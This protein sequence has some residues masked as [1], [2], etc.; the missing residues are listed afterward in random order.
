MQRS[1]SKQ[2]EV[3]AHYRALA[4]KY[5][6]R[7]NR[8]CER[9]YRALAHR[10]LAGRDRVL[11][12]GGGSSDLL[13]SLDRPLAVACDL[14]EEMLRSRPT[15]GRT[16]RVAA[17]CERLPFDDAGF[18]AILLVNVLEHVDDLDRVL[19]ES[20]RVLRAGGL[21]LAVTPNGDWETW[22][23]LAE[24]WSL[25]IPEGPHEF[26]TSRRLAEAV[27]RRLEIVEHRTMLTLP[28][29]PPALSRWIDRL[30]ACSARGW[31]FFQYV[32]A[33]KRDCRA[34]AGGP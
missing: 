23:D 7:A 3:K 27:G 4:P 1:T 32:A 13:D 17:V 11:E 33:R 21:W 9:T 12:L 6:D 31:G 2:A 34:A 30:S 16:H 18:D 14:S 15:G 8:T 24:R 20:A 28:A 22:L 19:A 26:L 25:K 5:G 10:V 29:G